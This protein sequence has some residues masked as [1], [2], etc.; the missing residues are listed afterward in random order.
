MDYL[1]QS[2]QMLKGWIEYSLK[3][4]YTCPDRQE[5]MCYGAGY[6]GWGMQTHQKALAAFATIATEKEIDMSDMSISREELLDYSLK[7]FRFML[8]SHIEG[9]YHCTEGDKWGHTWIS[10]LGTERAMHGIERLMA[11]MTEQDKVLL[12]KVLIS[13]A[14]WLMDCYDIC[15]HEDA[16]TGKNKP[17]S[18]IWN[19]AFL[20]R[21]AMMYP[22]CERYEEYKEKG[23]KYLVNGIS[24]PSDAV[25]DVVY[26]GKT[27]SE[28]FVGNNFFSSYSLDHHGYLNVGYM[29]IC[30]SNIAMLHFSCKKYGIEAPK[31]LYHHAA[32]LWKLIKSCIFDDGRLIRVGGD[33]RIRYCYCQDYLLPTFLFIRDFVGDSDC[34][35]LE[36]AIVSLFNKEYQYNEDGSF[37][38]KRCESF[39]ILSPIYYT[40]LESDK[41]VVLSMLVDWYNMIGK[42]E[43]S[44]EK[45][46]SWHEPFHGA[47][48]ERGKKRFA[49][50]TWKGAQGAQG[51]CL[52]IG[53]GNLA[54]WEDNLAGEVKGMSHNDFHTE[55]V[56][57][58]ERLFDGGFIT[59]GTINRLADQFVAEQQKAEVTA[60]I[61][62]VFAALPDD[63]TTVVMQYAYTHNRTYVKT[64]KGLK[65]N[66][67]NDVYNDFKRIYYYDQQKKLSTGNNGC[68]EVLD[69]NGNWINIDDSLGVIKGYGSSKLSIYCPGQRKVGIRNVLYQ[70]DTG[71]L[72]SDVICGRLS[73]SPQWADKGE[74]LIDEGAV[75]IAG[76]TAKE[77]KE[78]AEKQYDVSVTGGSMIRSVSV[79]GNDG[80]IY[81]VL[82]NFGKETQDATVHF[83]GQWTMKNLVTGAA[84]EP[85]ISIEGGGAEIIVLEQA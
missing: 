21:V 20:H 71:N 78:L 39:K 11:Y 58:E 7:M 66:V 19:G 56:E 83:K 63:A 42:G 48:F 54:E 37:L 61:K 32:E 65:L 15:A 1:N 80:K 75:V 52:P 27:V 60:T 53:K 45:L 79:M 5:L 77:T 55:C 85:V 62:I 31:A 3:D 17:E 73:L 72:C 6:N 28:W 29:V 35:K 82:S 81:I 34:D 64:I 13:E 4:L 41:A 10:V 44:I 8:E 30:L 70:R 43:K 68:E 51:L 23:T 26:D 38:S 2:R 46:I 14:D 76:V 18:N 16:R 57:H 67:P 33:T 12:K 47:C 69:V 9:D 40:R 22:D 59:S 50:W 36:E 49:S 74:V 84:C 25:S 24:I